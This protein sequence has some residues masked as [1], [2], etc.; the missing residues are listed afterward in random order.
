MPFWVVPSLKLGKKGVGVPGNDLECRSVA[1]RCSYVEVYGDDITDLLE[2]K[3]VGAW[4]GVASKAVAQGLA[5]VTIST[6]DE[7]QQCMRTHP[8]AP[9]PPSASSS[10]ALPHHHHASRPPP[11]P[12]QFR[13]GIWHLLLQY[14]GEARRTSGGRPLR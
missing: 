9:H 5:A 12:L 3:P 4:R 13:C 10:P 2:A 7:M 14:S 1:G 6:K 11:P 8:M